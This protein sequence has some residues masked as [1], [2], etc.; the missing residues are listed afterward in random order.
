MT[1]AKIKVS[2]DG[3]GAWC[4]NRLIELLGRSLKCEC[5]YLHA[6]ETGSG[7]KAGI[8]KWLT[9]YNSERPHSIHGIL[10]LVGA[11]AS[12]TEPMRLAA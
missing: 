7:A 12:K 3:K 11:D 4:D 2:M 1:N 10:T 8:G 5:V 6:F 9:Y